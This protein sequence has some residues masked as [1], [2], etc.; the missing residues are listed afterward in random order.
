MIAVHQYVNYG[1][2]GICKIEELR[3]VKFN[4][5][6]HARDYYILKPV[7]QENAQ[8]YVP[9]K[10]QALLD[11]MRPILSPE[12]IDQ[13]ILSIQDQDRLWI[14][15]RTK[16]LARFWEILSG[17]DER[18]LLLLAS[19]LY[20]KYKESG[21]GLCSSDAEIL[22]QAE[23][24]IEQEISFSLKMSTKNIGSLYSGETGAER[25]KNKG[26]VFLRISCGVYQGNK[27]F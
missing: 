9:A 7:Y 20:R 25:V 8:I 23:N 27:S 15:G 3:S 11:K 21:K 14:S 10:N 4:S 1:T 13:I 19:C 18:E 2:Q 6:S 22:K 12:E 26:A 17:R 16:R 24:A 5:D